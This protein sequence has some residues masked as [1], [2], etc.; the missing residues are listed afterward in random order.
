MIWNKLKTTT[1]S[2][3][4]SLINQFILDEIQSIQIWSVGVREYQLFKQISLKLVK[5]NI[6]AKTIRRMK[7][8]QLVS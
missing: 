7:Y 6:Y 5:L 4:N 2:N 8:N 3:L 1:N